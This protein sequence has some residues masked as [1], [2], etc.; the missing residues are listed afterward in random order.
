M[1][2][3]SYDASIPA[4]MCTWCHTEIRDSPAP[5]G[6]TARAKLASGG[7]A[8]GR[9]CSRSKAGATGAFAVMTKN[10]ITKISPHLL[11]VISAGRSGPVDPRATGNA[12]TFEEPPLCA[13]RQAA[14]RTPLLLRTR[15]SQRGRQREAPRPGARR[16]ASLEGVCEGIGILLEPAPQGYVAREL[17]D[18]PG[19]G[20]TPHLRVWGGEAGGGGRGGAA[21]GAME[22][23]GVFG[24]PP[25]VK[26]HK[27]AH[28]CA[29]TELISA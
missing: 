22:V 7:R 4:Y 15:F 14:R 27:Q 19:V 28:E 21:A 25:S 9:W 29:R 17:V 12:N 11:L 24:R 3:N 23:A 20:D 5:T 8:G 13:P 26:I 16:G 1:V 6:G 18:G 2:E 10:E